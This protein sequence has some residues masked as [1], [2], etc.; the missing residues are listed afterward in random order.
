MIRTL[1]YTGLFCAFLLPLRSQNKPLL[2]NF[3]E[4]PQQ[5]MVNPG[6]QIHQSG[7]I[8]VP[9]LSGISAQFGSSGFNAYDLF[10]DNDVNFNIK[11]RDV[12]YS[13][14]RNDVID[15]NEQVEIVFAGF[16]GRGAAN[17]NF[18]TFGIYQE[19]DL[20]NY[21]PEDLAYLAYEGNAGNTGRAYDLKDLNVQGEIFTTFHFGI[22]RRVNKDWTYGARLKLYSSMIHMSSNDNAGSF[23]TVPGTENIYSHNVIAN[24]AWNTSG[25]ASLKDQDI[26]NAQELLT[27]IAPN[28]LFGGNYGLGLDVGFTYTPNS[29]WTYSASLTDIGMMFHRSDTE[30]YTLKGAYNLEGIEF[31]FGQATDDD[32]L[33]QYWD[34]LKEDLEEQLPLDTISGSFTSF[35]P[36]KFNGAVMYNF[37]NLKYRKTFECE[38]DIDDTGY[39][40]S[41]G[42]QLYA[43]KRPQH[44]NTALTA[45][46]YRRIFN[47]LRAKVTYTVNPYTYTDIGLGISTHFA[48][49]NVY[50]LAENLLDYPNLAKANQAS[51]Q[52]GINYIL[53][54]SR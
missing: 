7:Y 23:I 44:V 31:L 26:D 10:A 42:L 16:K 2:F 52:F 37:G 22:N 49:F 6:A 38:C 24:M 33:N 32:F 48:N 30:S 19:L 51:V 4:I 8:G 41:V 40:N 35:R 20:Y 15:I 47:F 39:E 11:V 29:N 46:Y 3:R 36:V 13:L 9:F 45:F 18:Y 5:V 50:L 53:T 21:W 17:K 1:L 54:G 43:V 34:D 28:S 27:A 25:Y 14:D 12:L